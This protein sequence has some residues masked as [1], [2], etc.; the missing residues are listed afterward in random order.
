MAD[1][2]IS[3]SGM[4]ALMNEPG[5]VSIIREKAEGIAE[6]A[7]SQ[8]SAD[9]MDNRP[10]MASLDYNQGF[11]HGRAWTASPHGQ[12]AEAKYHALKNSIR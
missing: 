10:F 2:K 1:V 7:C 3:K 12:Y 4:R 11:P 8:C 9:P 6:N 5:I